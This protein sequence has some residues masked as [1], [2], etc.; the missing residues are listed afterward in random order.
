MKQNIKSP[1]SRTVSDNEDSK[2]YS[3][4]D[5]VTNSSVRPVN[6]RSSGNVSLQEERG[7]KLQQ[8]IEKPRSRSASKGDDHS[9]KDTDTETIQS[10]MSNIH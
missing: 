7:R 10:S 9:N 1:N 2:R 4:T 6:V 8:S 3:I 5:I